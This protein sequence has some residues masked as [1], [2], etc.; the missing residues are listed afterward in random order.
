[1]VLLDVIVFATDR[2]GV[3]NKE[4]DL[5]EKDDG[6]EPGRSMSV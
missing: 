1:M 3:R 4:V 2:D 6:A 5:E